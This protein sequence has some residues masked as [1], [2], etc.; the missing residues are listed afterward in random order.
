M[1]SK[2]KIGL[3]GVVIGAAIQAVVMPVMAEEIHGDQTLTNLSLGES[4]GFDPVQSGQPYMNT[5]VG[6]NA[7]N[8]LIQHHNSALGAFA[9]EKNSDGMQNTALGASA[10]RENTTGSYNT[11]VGVASL[12]QN[13]SGQFNTAI[14]DGALTKNTVGNNN[15]AVGNSALQQNTG[16]KDNVAIGHLSMMSNVS[17]INNT[18]VGRGALIGLTIGHSNTAIGF[19]AGNNQVGDLNVFIGKQAG[20]SFTKKN[21]NNKLIIA[22]G[23]NPENELITG[24]FAQKTIDLNGSVT[25][26]TGLRTFGS[27][28]VNK[29]IFTNDHL[30]VKKSATAQSFNTT[31][32][33]RLKNDIRPINDAL[34]S[35]LQLQ[36][37]SYRWNEDEDKQDIGLIAQDVEQ[38][39]PQLVA[40]DANGFKAI[41]YSRLTAVLVEAI[42]EQQGQIE[43][44]QQENREL[45]SRI[46][47]E[48]SLL[49]S[50]VSV[51][52]GVPLAQR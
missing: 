36:G 13:L 43:S 40:E 39:F 26:K 3:K 23:M 29:T 51:L 16:G 20:F 47:S 41:A 48:L 46:D 35:V 10:L 4:I 9:L 14:G 5:S 37:K 31:S 28:F 7:L 45:K 25:V 44:L 12:T 2:L 22:N 18:A 49:L 30:K 15:V 6:A 21:V 38:I 52:E 17:G 27:L 19:Y 33:E 1:N 42:K 11:A 34:S 8:P 24:D 32:D 50:R